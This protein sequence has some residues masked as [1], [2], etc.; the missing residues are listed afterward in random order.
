[1][2]TNKNDTMQKNCENGN[3]IIEIK[4]SLA[5]TECKNITKTKELERKE[6]NRQYNRQYYIKNRARLE[7]CHRKY[8]ANNKKSIDENKRKYYLNNRQLIRK[9]QKQY[10]IDNSE[11]LKLY[12]INT[13][14]Q[15]RQD[16][17]KH[18]DKI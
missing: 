11:K 6:Y 8:N 7:E 10:Q 1:M 18:R 4:K 16:Q 15:K 2:I 13:K 3:G 5:N 9:K 14:E 17:L 12:R